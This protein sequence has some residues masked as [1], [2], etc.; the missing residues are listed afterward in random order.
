MLNDPQVAICGAA[1]G[2]I[3][4][5]SREQQSKA[6]IMEADAVPPLTELMFGAD[7]PAQV[8][9]AGALL[10]LLGPHLEA[11]PVTGV[12]QP[13]HLARR[14]ALTRIVML[15]LVTGMAFHGL[16]TDDD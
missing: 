16:Y 15:S 5:L 6:E 1:A 4:N 9:A 13:E 12:Q 3:Q 11:D 10:N 8:C 14:Q 2:A 7:V